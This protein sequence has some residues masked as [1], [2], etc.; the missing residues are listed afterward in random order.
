MNEISRERKVLCTIE[1]SYHSERDDQLGKLRVF[2]EILPNGDVTPINSV[3]EFCFTNQVFVTSGFRD[4]KEKFGLNLFEATCTESRGELK[5]GDCRYVTRFDFCEEVKGLLASQ[6]YEND[7]PSP[8]QPSIFVDE[9]PITRSILLFNQR[10]EQYFGPFEY[11]LVSQSEGSNVE[12]NIKA[13]S[14]PFSNAIPLYHIGKF[15]S[16]TI[17]PYKR[18]FAQSPTLVGNIKKLAE[19]SEDKIDFIT[20]DQIISMYGNKVAQSSAIRN[21]T[22]GTVGLIRKHFSTSKEYRAFPDRF[23]RLLEALEQAESW[24]ASRSDIFESFLRDTNGIGQQI[25][26]KYLEENKERFFQSEKEAYQLELQTSAENEKKAI[27][28][29]KQEKEKLESEN[30]RL[31]REQTDL[32]VGGAEVAAKLEAAKQ[33]QLSSQ[34]TDLQGQ[35][36]QLESEYMSMENKYK[37]FKTLDDLEQEIQLIERERDRAKEKN[38]GIEQQLESIRETLKSENDELTRK[39]VKL[40]P[41]VDALCGITPKLPNKKVDYKVK[42]SVKKDSDNEAIREELI[43][44]VLDSLNSQGRKTDY[45]TAA[46]ILTTVAQCQFTLFSGLPGTGKTSLAKMLGHGLGLGNR[47]LNVPVARGWTSSRDVMGF[48]NA[49]S[50]SYVPSSTGLYELL[51]QLDKE[52]RSSEE[53]APSIVLLDEFNL[54]QPEHYFSP[55]ME[56]ADPESR[57]IIATGDMEKPTLNVPHYLR[58][59][60]TINQ[61]ESVQALT[62]RMLDRAAIIN[63]DEF[64]SNY[65]LAISDITPLS[66][67]IIPISGNK[68]IEI[69]TPSSL[70]L[71]DNIESILH[72]IITTLR[73]DDPSLG[74]PILISYRKLKA[75]RAY[76]NV[77]S[78][79]MYE[80]TYAALDYAVSQHI[81]PLL[82]GYGEGFGQ[83]LENLLAILPEE[84]ERSHKMLNRTISLGKQN[85]YSFGANI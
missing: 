66:T 63:F 26:E 77:A 19:K 4:I 70:E 72:S 48:Y 69:F 2:F 84:M 23:Q 27:S 49:L 37:K 43:D 8:S 71:K 53:H 5:D 83:R 44:S 60:G 15:N 21:F 24:D 42:V 11:E 65:D 14:T 12:L 54:S 13:L 68:F 25:L 79:L 10:T 36:D 3:E 18:E 85:M 20:D 6:V 75:I 76:H 82:N 62:P 73:N 50:Q 39:L 35:L 59:V 29:L 40:K 7:L 1:K 28:L 56:M 17:A 46:N 32:E 78:P 22:K 51:N 31:A 80:N 9:R 81:I 45:Y 55:F 67:P 33:N 64:E 52:Q 41:E 47:F 61:D 74:S 34:I 30:R 38:K 16:S 57:R 58:F